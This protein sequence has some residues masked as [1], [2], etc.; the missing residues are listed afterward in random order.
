S[1]MRA[2][3]WYYPTYTGEYEEVTV[4]HTVSL[5][6]PE[7]AEFRAQVPFSYRRSPEAYNQA[8]TACRPS[9]EGMALY[10]EAR[11]DDDDG[12]RYCCRLYP[13]GSLGPVTEAD[14]EEGRRL[15]IPAENCLVFQGE[16]V[17]I[18]D[19]ILRRISD[20]STV[21][22]GLWTS[23]VHVI[24]D[25]GTA[26]GPDS[27]TDR[28]LAAAPDGSS[29]CVYSRYGGN[30]RYPFLVFPSDLDTLVEKGKKRLKNK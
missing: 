18:D 4:A 15:W 2:G 8:L 24:S 16:E 6:D 13:D 26:V 30:T 1:I 21:L 17:Y 29:I 3:V 27:F 28:S 20:G 25:A 5:Y 10:W 12:E 23:T 11:N 14:S 9:E 19:Q 22:A 7:K